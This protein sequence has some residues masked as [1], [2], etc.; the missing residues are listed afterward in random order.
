MDI[1]SYFLI[2]LVVGALLYFF[3]HKLQEIKDSQGKNEGNKLMLEVVEKLR[4][5]VRN[6]LDKNS[7]S[8]QKRLD[9]TL[10][11]L[12]QQFNNVRKGVD[13]RISENTKEL[14]KR[15]DNA[16]KVIFGVKE[17]LGRVREVGDQIKKLQEVLGGQKLRG[18]LGEQIMNDLITQVIPHAHYEFQYRF[19]T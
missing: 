12:D 1:F 18:N 5:E 6:G 4:S 14:N 17:E 7:E 13:T 8:L 9:E 15:L 2:L 11:L 3:Y 16:S 10:K 19:Q